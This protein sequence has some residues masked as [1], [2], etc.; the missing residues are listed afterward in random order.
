MLDNKQVEGKLGG[1]EEL[2]GE[3]RN[4]QEREKNCVRKV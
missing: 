1:K 2:M 3:G 4:D